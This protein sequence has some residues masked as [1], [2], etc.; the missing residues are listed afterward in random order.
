MKIG[1]FVK[2]IDCI[3]NYNLEGVG[4]E[5]WMSVKHVGWKFVAVI[6]WLMGQI[7]EKSHV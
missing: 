4:V 1:D 3:N 5:Q 6:A 2:I 7:L